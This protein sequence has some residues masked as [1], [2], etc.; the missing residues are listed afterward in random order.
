MGLVLSEQREHDGCMRSNG[1]SRK[2]PWWSRWSLEMSQ[3]VPSLFRGVWRTALF[4]GYALLFIAIAFPLTLARIALGVL[5][6]VLL[7]LLLLAASSRFD[8]D[9]EA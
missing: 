2:S 5:A 4:L 1:L 6:I 3:L 7:N 9:P 8:R